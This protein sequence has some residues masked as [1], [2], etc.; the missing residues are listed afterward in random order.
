MGVV[1]LSCGC[2]RPAFLTKSSQSG[3]AITRFLLF[4]ILAL[5]AQFAWAEVPDNPGDVFATLGRSQDVSPANNA[6]DQAYVPDEILVAF[7]PGVKAAEVSQARKALGAKQI[8]T[9]SRIRVHHWKIPKGLSPAKAVE[10]IQRRPGVEYAEPNYIFTI[11]AMPDDPRTGELW[12][13]HNVGQT[14]GTADADIDAPEAWEVQTDASGIVVGIIDTGIDFSHEDLASNI[15]VNEAELTGKS[16][17]DDDGNGYIDDFHGWDWVNDDNDPFDD[18]GHGTHVA[19][20]VCGA[21]DNGTGVVG[22]AWS[23]QLA[24]LK[25]LSE[26]GRGS[27]DDAVSAVLYAADMGF[28]VTNNSWSGGDR[29][30]ALN[31]AIKASTGIF[32][33]SAGNW[34]TSKIPFPAAYNVETIVAVAATDHDDHLASFSN[35]NSRLVDLA[36]PGVD[37]LSS[38]PGDEYGTKS[39]TS[40]AAPHVTGVV[41]LLMAYDDTLTPLE[42]KA[43]IMETVDPL[44][45]LAG[46]M[47]T[48]GR[49]NAYAALGSPPVTPPT[50]DVPP[51]AVTDLAV[52][53]GQT[54]SNSMQ[55]Q[56]TAPFDDDNDLNSGP[57][58]AYDLRYRTDGSIDLDNWDS[59]TVVENV[60]FP[61]SPGSLETVMVSD[62]EGRPLTTSPFVPLTMAVIHLRYRTDATI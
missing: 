4:S 40:M 54:T 21:G 17:V 11:D 61:A 62:L 58:L 45:S 36:A 59:S 3:V 2:L 46:L 5:I 10:I 15:W 53:T 1:I 8:K 55:L 9:F 33:A 57:V 16:G 28:P 42:V 56:W 47:V 38:L 60:P 19:G 20:T 7:R 50:D 18:N 27:T 39:G 43:R 31:D 37:I 14:G 30:K 48:G 25:F 34:R 12:G 49:I 52:L 6:M 13:L 24:A 41:T 32:V 35:Y 22:V 26:S 51:N 23:C 29:S 44:P